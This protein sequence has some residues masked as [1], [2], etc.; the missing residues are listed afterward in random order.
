MHYD[1][2]IIGA[3][4]GGISVANFLVKEGKNVLILEKNSIPGGCLTSFERNGFR[5]DTGH[6]GLAELAPNDIIPKFLEY[7]GISLPARQRVDDL[8]INMN[9]IDYKFN[10]DSIQ[11]DLC[12]I[13]PYN[14]KEIDKFFL[15][16]KLIM[17]EMLSSGA[18]QSTDDMNTFR[19]LAFGVNSLAKKP[20]LMKYGI[21]N[22]SN[23]LRTIFTNDELIKIAFSRLPMNAVYLAQAYRW[24]TIL[25]KKVYYPISGGMQ[26][27]PNTAME[28]FLKNGGE[29]RYNNDVEKIL[30]KNNK[31]CG[32]KLKNSEEIESNIVISNVSVPFTVNNLIGK[33]DRNLKYITKILKRKTFPSAYMVFYGLKESMP[34]IN[35]QLSTIYS[36]DFKNPYDENELQA[37]NSPIQLIPGVSENGKQTLV[38]VMPFSYDYFNTDMKYY[39]EKKEIDEIIDRR[40][41]SVLGNKFTQNISLRFSG[42]PKTIERYTNS[43]RG[44]YMG[45]DIDQENYGRFLSRQSPYNNLFYCGQ[46]VFPGFGAAGVMAS[47]YYLSNYLLKSDKVNLENKFKEYFN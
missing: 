11:N 9:G 46:Y 13:F 2:I 31:A 22:A 20:K 33:D 47:G 6:E 41:I 8:H 35:S 37:K 3:G 15:L 12:E 14:R 16:N 43:Y 44:S 7:W 34:E 10:V 17:N 38:A 45:W 26:A 19:K 28:V 1:Y 32:V 5:F 23:V 30:I 18:P 36:N 21:K 39:E 29:V 25:G 42:S 4:L 27:L 24:Q 40:I